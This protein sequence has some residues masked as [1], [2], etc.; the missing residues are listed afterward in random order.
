MISVTVHFLISPRVC[1]I[2]TVKMRKN[3]NNIE[4]IHEEISRRIITENKD[5]VGILG[6]DTSIQISALLKT[7]GP[8]QN[9]LHDIVSG[10][11][12]SDKMDYLLRD[13]YYAGVKYGM[14]DL[15]RMINVLTLTG[16]NDQLRLSVKQ[17]GVQTVEQYVLAK[18]FIAQQVYQHKIRHITDHMIIE[19]IKNSIADGNDELKYIYKY[20]NDVKYI[21][22]YLKSNDQ[23]VFNSIFNNS[24]PESLGYQ[25]FDM[26]KNRRLLKEL[27]N[28]KYVEIVRRESL[29]AHQRLEEIKNGNFI[30]L[31]KEI[32]TKTSLHGCYTYIAVYSLK[33]PL[34]KKSYSTDE[35]SIRIKK[36]P[37]TTW[38]LDSESELFTEIINNAKVYRI[39]VFGLPSK[40][41]ISEEYT[42]IEKIIEAILRE[43]FGG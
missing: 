33:S 26:L 29:E 2:I 34:V 42:A 10:S 40:P 1:L 25:Y 9:Y 32:S 41:L 8:S 23:M 27:F 38:V 31:A 43:Y 12:D 37:K 3:T 6:V 21:D 19:G 15:E 13:S 16:D 11:I 4:E 39:A 18:Y 5:I 22:N 7:D 30:D 35:Q 14:F 36:G 24:K 28:R 20:E 17:E